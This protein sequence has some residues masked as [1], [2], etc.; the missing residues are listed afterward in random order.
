[1]A[2]TV[3]KEH[4]AF[5][6]MGYMGHTEFLLAQQESNG[7]RK[8]LIVDLVLENFIQDPFIMLGATHPTQHYIP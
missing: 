2:P 8:I 7:P 6:L 4:I 1:V 3:S 5:I